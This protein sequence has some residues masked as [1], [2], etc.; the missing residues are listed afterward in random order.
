[1]VKHEM[2][3]CIGARSLASYLYFTISS[4]IRTG[5]IYRVHS[6]RINE[7]AS[8]TDQMSLNLT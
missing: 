8:V 1:M 4:Y 3:L 6:R 7:G 2:V 5:D